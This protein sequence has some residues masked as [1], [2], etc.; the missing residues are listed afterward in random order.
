M[1]TSA[2]WLWQKLGAFERNT[3]ACPVE[4]ANEPILPGQKKDR[5]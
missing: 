2:Y 5:L 3:L 1:P 4:I